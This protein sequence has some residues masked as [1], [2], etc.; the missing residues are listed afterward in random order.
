MS[1]SKTA[2]YLPFHHDT[3]S[4]SSGLVA[5]YQRL[6]AENER[7][8]LAL[9]ASGVVGLWDW[10]VDTDLLHGDA[11]FARLY[12]LD[13][14][15]TAAGL[16]MEQY[17]EFVVAED[18]QA[19]RH[20]IRETFERGADFLVEYRLAIPDHQLRWVECKGRLIGD[21][22]GRPLRFSGTAIDITQRKYQE[23][24]TYAAA[25]AARENAERMQL[26]LAAGAIIGTWVWDIQRDE[27]S[28]DEGLAKAF[29]L[30]PAVGRAGPRMARII[31]AVHPDD[32]PALLAAVE[33]AIQACASYAC[34][35]RVRREDGGY[36]WVEAN[37]RVESDS[38]GQA[39]RF[40][41][42]L[43]DISARRAV[44]NERD[45]IAADLRTLNAT[46]E[47]RIAERTAE[48]DRMWETSPDLLLIVDFDGYVCRVNPAWT[49]L[50]GYLPE[51]LV[52]HHV[53]E[54]VV[55]DDHAKT[56]DAYEEAGAGRSPRVENC[57]RHKDG[58]LRWL[59]W[60]AAPAGNLTY[61]TGRDVTVEKTRA[62]TLAETQEALRQS[63]K[64]EAVGQL[65][66]GLAHDFN[67]LL[68][69]ISGSL[70]L[71]SLRIEHGQFKD[72]GRFMLIAQN[73]VK[74]A[75]SL[76][77]RLLAFSR[78]QTLDPKAA[79][80]N[81]LIADM[82]ELIQRTVGPS[83]L[84]ELAA[85]PQAW[86]A[87]VDAPQLENA[88]LNLCINARD[89][90]PE[91]GRIRIETANNSLDEADARMHDIAPGQYLSL[92]V[93]D[94]GTGIAAEIIDR[95]FDPFFTTKPLGAGT[96][97]GLS[98]VYGFA[99]QSG[100]QVSVV[101]EIG[102]GTTIC[103]YLPRHHQMAEETPAAHPATISAPSNLN[104][105]VLVVDD[106]PTIRMLVLEMLHDLGFN[107]IEAGD[108]AAGLTI[109]RSNTDIDLLVSDVGL[110]GG[111]NGRQMAD[112]A[113]VSRPRLKVLFITAYADNAGINDG[114]LLPGMQ[115]MTKPFEMQALAERIRTMVES[116][117]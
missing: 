12:G 19:L 48:R 5:N 66:G 117:G 20:N 50:L 15:C 110:P 47:Q 81:R 59:S 18:L 10:M 40:P 90:M 3:S 11:N 2:P 72:I 28:T 67:N 39:C 112:A 107:A 106:E 30:D 27:F 93:T 64:M 116:D 16:T 71:M 29:G 114:H 109:L 46:L 78:R 26:A 32:K 9:E 17:Q 22:S 89:A 63:Q 61:A 13:P 4:A 62:A 68:A 54:F 99:K 83:V 73:G 100:G 45:R 55:A 38:S 43:I 76:T 96:G 14:S 37:G 85:M 42:V 88:L 49:K 87:L 58:S 101:S 95:V 91:G 6:R 97:L 35:Y 74:R 98:M 24:V 57:Y 31:D 60:V 103:I 102:T 52:G 51:E 111:L 86:P 53:N 79:D 34:Q 56:V 77:H 69:G 82:H 65:T 44:E 104:R 33:V 115:V 1:S 8:Q 84:I 80:V 94:T 21:A 70:E 41:G 25:V 113:R 23:A 7:L 105:T 75:A 92:C 108:S 36:D